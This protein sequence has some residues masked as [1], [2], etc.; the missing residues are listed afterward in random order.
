[1][2]QGWFYDFS[3]YGTYDRLTSDGISQWHP[4]FL[5]LNYWG[6]KLLAR[7]R[8][9]SKPTKKK[10]V[11]PGQIS[12]WDDWLPDMDE[13]HEVAKKF[14]LANCFNPDIAAAQFTDTT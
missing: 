4:S 7:L 14:V 5:R 1:M 3:N 10:K 13:V 12:L 2:Q 9:K 6:S 8:I 11:S